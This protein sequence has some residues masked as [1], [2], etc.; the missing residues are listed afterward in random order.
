MSLVLHS[1]IISFV[2]AQP[3]RG[4]APASSVRSLP[5]MTL[6]IKGMM[7]LVTLRSSWTNAERRN[8]SEYYQVAPGNRLG[9]LRSLRRG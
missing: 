8:Y 9:G 3:A 6:R 2:A 5:E 4:A 7:Q 1:I